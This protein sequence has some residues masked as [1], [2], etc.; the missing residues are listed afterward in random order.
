MPVDVICN[1]MDAIR[2]QDPSLGHI[3]GSLVRRF[4]AVPSP[5]AFSSWVSIRGYCQQGLQQALEWDRAHGTYRRLYSRA[6]FAASHFLAA[7]YKALRPQVFWEAEFSDPL[8]HDVAGRPRH[9]PAAQD[10]LLATF[11]S[12][13]LAAGWVPPDSDNIYVWCETLAFALADRI[14]FTNQAQLEFMVGAC[15]DPV[16]AQRARDVAKVSPHPTLPP[17]YYDLAEPDYPLDPAQRHIGY[18]GNFYATRGMDTVLDALQTIPDRDR[19]R[20]ALHVFTS[21]PET[22]DRA[23]RERGLESVVHAQPFADYLDFLALTRRLDCLLVND[24]IS[25]AGAGSNPFLPSKWSDYRGSGSAV[26]G[27]VEEGS[28][29]SGQPLDHR[30]PIGHVTAAQQVLVRIAR[31]G[32]ESMSAAGPA[33]TGSSTIWR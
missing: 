9:S 19:E 29:L 26:W 8:S 16:L 27:V 30:S 33:V 12:M 6:Q 11:R 23:A 31:Q 7:R 22:L 18:F 1:A 4:E 28:P 14:L 20:L 13:L 25:P 21:A 2:R 24:S 17:E 3:A 5:T 10:E 32:T 15:T